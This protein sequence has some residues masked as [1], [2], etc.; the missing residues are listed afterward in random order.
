MES[1]IR[2]KGR[3]AVVTG[4]TRGI[5]FLI[6][7][8]LAT[9]GANVVLSSRSRAAVEAAHKQLATLPDIQVL[10]VECDVRDLHQVETLAQRTLERFGKIDIWFNNAGVN[11]PYARTVDIPSDRWRE[12][13]DTNLYGTYHGTT[14]A[15]KHMLPLNQGKIIN[16]LGAGDEDRGRMQFGY[17]SA[18]ATSK[19]AVRRFTLAVADE[20]R[21]TGISILGLNPGLVATDLT[22]KTEPLTD[23]ATERLKGLDLALA[24]FTTPL[25][26]IGEKV[27]YMASE[28]TDGTS[29]KIYR[30]KPGLLTIWQRWMKRSR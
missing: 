22:T 8:S 19:A 29:G 26:K 2:L 1:S 10:G 24:L 12:V 5:G 16:L 25:E 4:S 20:Y 3:I 13:I 27:V 11:S 9:A 28:A 6:A 7:K 15:L 21:D 14:V 18:Y 17:M 23:E 30:C